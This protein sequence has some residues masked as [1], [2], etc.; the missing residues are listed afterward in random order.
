MILV[1]P[2]LTS[3]SVNPTVLPGLIKTVEKYI[4]IH[5][6]D[7]VLR[8]INSSIARGVI[9]TAKGIA[10]TAATAAVAA[11]VSAYIHSK[12]SRI[13]KQG[14]ELVLKEQKL[15]QTQIPNQPGLTKKQYA[16]DVGQSV[17]GAIQKSQ[18]STGMIKDFDMPKYDTVSLEPTWVKINTDS[19]AKLLGV[20][21]VPFKVKSTT[22]MVGLLMNDSQL[23]KMETLANKFGRTVARVFF[24]AMRGIRMPGF[25]G[26][27]L[28]GDPK[29]DILW[30]TT[31][32]GKNMFVCLSQLDI[33]AD[34]MF[35]SPQAVQRL[36]KL[37]WA[38]LI[39]TD[40]VNKQATFCMKE[41]GGI[42]SVIP[43]SNMYASLGKEQHQV[44]KDLE[45]AQ[46]SAGPFFARKSTTKRKL[47]SDK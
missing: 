14:N 3:S 34:D 15:K 24:R 30:A 7:D 21:V 6:M 33:E 47:F 11:G 10:G 4:I 38:S 2:M 17:S 20:K 41:F 36:H 37:G 35:T 26:K 22:G 5:N 29:K 28:S 43:Y 39:I 18:T 16:Q 42:C 9:G 19:G 46:R 44:Y 12:T 23:K 25:S 27:A 1:Y 13:V 45:D 32:Y 31:Q 40:D 8:N